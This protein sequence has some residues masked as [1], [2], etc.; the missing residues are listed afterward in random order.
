MSA[1]SLVVELG[2]ARLEEPALYFVKLLLDGGSSAEA[3]QERTDVSATPSATPTFKSHSFSFH[4]P[5]GAEPEEWTLQLSA[6][7]VVPEAEVEASG[8]KTRVAGSATLALG[9]LLSPLLLGSARGEVK[10]TVE[11]LSEVR[12]RECCE[13]RAASPRPC[14]A[15]SSRAALPPPPPNATARHAA[16]PRRWT[17]LQ[18]ARS[19]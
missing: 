13:L 15:T 4:V 6:I 7:A 2:A 9:D 1:S 19:E 12:R 14:A 16:S 11:L 5:L 10:R 8:S 17:A 18:A 3:V